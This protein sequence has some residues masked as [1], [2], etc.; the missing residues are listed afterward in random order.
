MSDPDEVMEWSW[1]TSFSLQN[2]LG[3]RIV[4][5]HRIGQ[6]NGPRLISLSGNLE[7][8]ATAILAQMR[9]DKKI[10]YKGVTLICTEIVDAR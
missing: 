4:H 9:T 1:F 7:G 6:L 5:I 2:G 10:H 3:E 8:V